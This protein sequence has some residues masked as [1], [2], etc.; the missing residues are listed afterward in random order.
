[1]N[2]TVLFGISDPDNVLFLGA[3]LLNWKLAGGAGFNFTP[4]N[5]VDVKL[6]VSAAVDEVSFGF[7]TRAKKGNTDLTFVLN[8]NEFY[9]SVKF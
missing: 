8:T 7:M 4:I 1:L 2:N 5:G 9:F 6:L 3:G